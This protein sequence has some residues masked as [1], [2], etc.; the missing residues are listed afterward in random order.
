MSQ[1]NIMTYINI[2]IFDIGNYFMRDGGCLEF[3]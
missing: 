2:T 3:R 1:E